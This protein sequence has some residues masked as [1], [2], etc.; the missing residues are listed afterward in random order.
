[1]EITIKPQS[2]DGV[3][4]TITNLIFSTYKETFEVIKLLEAIKDGQKI[5]IEECIKIF[6]ET[7]TG[8]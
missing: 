8:S 1:M 6:K 7:K 3:N 2:P 4:V 5:D